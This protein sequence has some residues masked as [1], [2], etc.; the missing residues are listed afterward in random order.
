MGSMNKISAWKVAGAYIGTVVGAGFASGQEVLQFFVFF[1]LRGVLAVVLA[2]AF[3]AVFGFAV[4]DLG[5]RLGARSHLPVI[6]HTGGRYV[7]GV[8]DAVTTFF[9][10][11]ALVA[12]A[13]GAGAIFLE[14]FRLA[15]ILGSVLMISFS[16]F[17]VLLGLGGVVTSISVVVPFLLGAV[18]LLGVLS[19]LGLHP[20]ELFGPSQPA[21]APVPSWP[22]SALVYTSYNMLLSVAVLAP[23]GR[24]GGDS[25]VLF[26]GALLGGLG[27]GIGAMA[28]FAA[29]SANLPESARFEIPMAFIAGR[30][31]P[32]AK[33][34]YSVVLLAE[35]YTTA[36]GSLY[37]FAARLTDPEGQRFRIYV[38][39]AATVAFAAAQVG[40]STVVRTLY[41]AVGYAGLLFLGTLTLGF[42]R[43]LRGREEK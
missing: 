10:F 6:R 11:G 18:L 2:T 28:V 33:G 35:I 14:Q 27:L 30:F 29:I 36:V 21:R 3:F 8:I 13:A 1:G 39:V 5:R 19:I 16:M 37:G 40:F 43:S 23:L 25:R 24:L 20:S 31:S 4:L 34:V 9:L 12:M 26:R 38:V 22:L 7:G 15:K 32:V 41:P 42:F 17:T